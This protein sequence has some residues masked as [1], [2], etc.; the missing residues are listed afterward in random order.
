MRRA[1][2]VLTATVL[3]T[4]GVL[5]FKPLPPSAVTSASA[6]RDDTSGA[7]TPAAEPSTTP[8]SSSSGSSSSSSAKDGTF[9]GD[10]ETTRFG[11]T[12][13]KVVVSGGRI[14][15]VVTVQLNQND[16]RSMQ[17]SESAA[18]VLRSEVLSAQKAAVDTVS[19][20]TYTSAAYEASLQS[21]LD[22]AGFAAAD[23]SKASTDLSRVEG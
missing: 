17:I 20:A 2:I 1:P 7:S 21:A 5:L 23:G 6:S 4:A 11:T 16:P 9:S 13:V 3:G 15:D 19:G 12:Q 22:R 8:S 14:T 10:A 18:P